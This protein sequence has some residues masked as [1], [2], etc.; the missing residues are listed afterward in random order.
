MCEYLRT[1]QGT[2]KKAQTPKEVES[3]LKSKFG[4]KYEFDTSNY[5]GV[6]SII[7]VR[8]TEHGWFSKKYA[9]VSYSTVAGCTKCAHLSRAAKHPTT[10]AYDLEKGKKQCKECRLW[11]NI[12]DYP[13]RTWNNGVD[14]KVSSICADCKEQERLRFVSYNALRVLEARLRHKKRQVDELQEALGDKT[15]INFNH[16]FRCNKTHCYQDDVNLCK[17]C[18]QSAVGK[19]S[20]MVAYVKKGTKTCKNCL[21]EFYHFEIGAGDS[22][23]SDKCLSEAKRL[24]R[25]KNAN[26]GNIRRRCK[27]YGAYYEPVNRN[28]VLQRDGN[29]CKACN[30]KVQRKDIYAENAAELDHIVPLSKGG[31][32]TYSNIQTLCRKCNAE[33]CDNMP[34]GVQPTLFCSLKITQ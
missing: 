19:F 17:S 16:C 28:K 5:S 6:K 13:V 21:G 7:K 18:L 10:S 29:R 34:I 8:C 14:K 2:A 20:R 25:K 30:V 33:K 12:N 11:I 23:C 24:L 31:A 26:S 9:N 3:K 27:K 1:N 22:Y 4:D 32:H 15:D